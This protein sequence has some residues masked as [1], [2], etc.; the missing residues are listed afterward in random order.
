MVRSLNAR[1][2]ELTRLPSITKKASYHHVELSTDS[3]QY[4]FGFEWVGW[5]KVRFHRAGFRLV[6]SSGTI[7]IY[8]S[9]SQAVAQY[10][11]SRDIP[12]LT[13]ID[14]FHLLI[15][16][17]TRML[18]AAEQFQAALAAAYV[19]LEG[20]V[21]KHRLLHLSPMRNRTYYEARVSWYFLR[22]RGMPFRGTGRQVREAESHF[23]RCGDLWH[24][25]FSDA[26]DSCRKVY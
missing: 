22:L 5:R 17:S 8:A 11:R 6:F 2:R 14:D 13:W 7:Y 19:A 12:T 16:G 9:L 15:F 1:G 23:R 4:Y 26:R 3:W 18:G 25:Y 24:D 21:F 20:S 10:L